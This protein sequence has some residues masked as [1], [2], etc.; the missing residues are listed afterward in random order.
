ME[1]AMRCRVRGR[2]Q[3]VFFRDSTRRLAS[4]LGLRGHAVNLVDGSVEVLAGGDADALE[5]L[6]NWLAEGPEMAR[7]DSVECWWLDEPV[8]AMGFSIG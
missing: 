4:S 7:V 2:V 8:E 6:R 3:G 1:K 5:V